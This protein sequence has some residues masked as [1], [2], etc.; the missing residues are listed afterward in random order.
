MLKREFDQLA[1]KLG[2][3][4][5]AIH[6]ISQSA[7]KKREEVDYS[8]LESEAI[9][10]VLT[11]VAPK[12]RARHRFNRLSMPLID[13]LLS[14]VDDEE[15]SQSVRTS[16]EESMKAHHLIY[17]YHNNLDDNRKSRVRI[18]TRMIWYNIEQEGGLQE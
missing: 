17:H 5:S 16:Y 1:D 8:I 18:L 2:S 4:F 15:V 13:E 12:L 14:Y 9:T 7:R 11:G 6:Y 3:P 10:W